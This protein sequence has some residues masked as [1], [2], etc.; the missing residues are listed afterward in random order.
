V[1]YGGSSNA[2]AARP[3]PTPIETPVALGPAEYRAVWVDAFHDGIK[4]PAQVDR[5]VANAHEANLNALFVQVRKRGDAYYTSPIEPRPWDIFA[6]P[7]F[8][9]LGYLLRKAHGAN[10]PIEVHAWLNTFFVGVTG[11]KVYYQHGKEWGGR[12]YD[13]ST[14]GYLDPGNPEASAYTQEVF[15]EMAKRY[16]VDGIHLDFVRY[17]E[18][19]DWGY[20]PVSVARFNQARTRTGTPAPDDPAWSQWRRDQVTQ[21]IRGLNKELKRVK[22]KLRLSA[23]LIPWGSGPATDEAWQQTAA[24]S[25]VF[26]DW[27]S[28]LQEG[29]LDLAV[30]MNY[31]SEWSPSAAGWYDQWNN[32]EKDHGFSRLVLIGVGGFLNYP[33]DT[34]AQIRRAMAPSARG[35]RAAG[36]AIYSYAS[37]S[38]YGTDDYFA[39]AAAAGTLPRQPYAGG[40]DAAALT[41]R[42][43][44]FNRSFWS[45]LSRPGEYRD[46][47]KGPVATQPVFP[48]PAAIPNLPG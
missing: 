38:V 18:G 25:Q 5:L 16:P 41:A 19:G 37:T 17:P 7:S 44:Q 39:D 36:V 22:P 4:S 27:R 35:N 2:A 14:G 45:L 26:Q 13:G 21:F 46:P 31:N 43:D 8:D 1:T 40:L 11:T 29:L 15:V 6:P 3:S 10:P 33:E 28:W 24:Y 47:V 42:A 9:P 30:P 48:A 20:N 34:M 32:W 12:S 23:A